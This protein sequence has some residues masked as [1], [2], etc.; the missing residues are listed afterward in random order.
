MEQRRDYRESEF[1]EMISDL[2]ELTRKV[3]CE[4][5]T[6]GLIN[7]LEEVDELTKEPTREMLGRLTEH[8]ETYKQMAR[9]YEELYRRINGYFGI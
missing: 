8:V 9:I 5:D 4:L 1:P 3:E 2:D 7:E 6:D